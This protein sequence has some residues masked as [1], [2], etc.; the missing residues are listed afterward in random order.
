MHKVIVTIYKKE[1]SK[2]VDT[3]HLMA[4]SVFAAIKQAEDVC[5]IKKYKEYWLVANV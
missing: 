1:R 5:K 2:P 3:F 4:N